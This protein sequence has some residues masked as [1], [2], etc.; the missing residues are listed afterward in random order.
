MS[1]R[2]LRLFERERVHEL[3]LCAEMI[4]TLR[5][6]AAY[7]K[8]KRA[9]EACDVRQL[10]TLAIFVRQPIL[11]L[12]AHRPDEPYGATIIGLQHF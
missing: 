7:L 2:R 4:G 5:H 9:I 3:Q 10:L 8:T 12:V 11:S 1:G 6:G